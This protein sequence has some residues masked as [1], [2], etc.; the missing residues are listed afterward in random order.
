MA[1]LS[2]TIDNDLTLLGPTPANEWGTLIWGTDVWGESRNFDLLIEKCLSEQIS[3]SDSISAGVQYAKI[4]L[5]TLSLASDADLCC[6]QDGSGYN[7]VENGSSDLD[8]R[9]FPSYTEDSKDSIVYT[10]DTANDTDWSNS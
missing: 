5:N 4:L 9:Y 6:L 1:D 3:F 2:I 10:E 7:Y 8:D